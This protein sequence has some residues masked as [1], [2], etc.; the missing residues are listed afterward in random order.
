VSSQD[1]QYQCG[2]PSIGDNFAVVISDS[3]QTGFTHYSCW[4][5]LT[6]NLLHQN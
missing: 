6:V 4:I 3:P 1:N 2:Q 5:D